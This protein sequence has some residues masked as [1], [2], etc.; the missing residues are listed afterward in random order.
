MSKLHQKHA[1]KA[2]G[3]MRKKEYQVNGQDWIADLLRRG[4]HGTLASVHEGQPYITPL[5]YLYDEE[6]HALYFH[7]A[8]TGRLR[9]NI[10]YN[11]QV[12]FNV[13][14]WG[15]ILPHQQAAE[16]N[17]EYNSVTVFGTAALVEDE[18][19][20]ESV[21][22]RL[23]AKYAPHLKAG[24][25]YD[26][27]RPE[28]LKTTAVYRLSIEEWTGKQQKETAEVPGAFRYGEFPG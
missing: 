13:C 11:P 10:H 21:L 18:R 25:D 27:I 16:F 17:I 8:K 7:G 26:P 12:A 2:R 5:L 9:A 4:V 20:A 15:R 19:L 3:E 22:A 1:R 23:L 24:E 14:E 6:E 28:E